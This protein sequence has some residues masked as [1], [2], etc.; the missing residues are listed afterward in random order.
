MPW[1]YVPSSMKEFD[2]ANL[3][4][5]EELL[6]TSKMLQ[7]QGYPSRKSMIH[8]INIENIKANTTRWKGTLSSIYALSWTGKV[9][10]HS[11]EWKN[12]WGAWPPLLVA[13]LG[14][15]TARFTTTKYCDA[16]TASQ[17]CYHYCCY[18]CHFCFHCSWP[19]DRH[20]KSCIQATCFP[21]IFMKARSLWSPVIPCDTLVIPYG[22]VPSKIRNG[23]N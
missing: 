14:S 8:Y 4:V 7:V 23:T 16:S 21:D 2:E 20:Q 3:M 18:S 6:A 15:A 5:R 22:P 19:G 17:S 10:D 11:R 12:V 13:L 9:A 1:Y